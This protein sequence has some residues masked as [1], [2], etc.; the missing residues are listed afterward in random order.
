MPAADALTAASPLSVLMREGSVTE[1]REAERSTFMAAMLD[2]RINA[3]GYAAYVSAL[4]AVYAALEAVGRELAY[5]EVV[6]AIVDPRL[7][8]LTALDEDLRYW[9]Q[10]AARVPAEVSPTAV[11]AYVARL[12]ETVSD[13]VLYVAHHYTRYLGD[14][15]GGQAVG[16]ILAR[17]YGIER[18]G[19]GLAFYEFPLIEKPK[20]YKDRYRAQL[21]ALP[22]GPDDQHR[23]VQEVRVAF[24]H[25]GAMFSELSERLDE[26]TA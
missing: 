8:R 26:Y 3:T 6:G 19:A 12:R 10:R 14:L 22:L 13:P 16:R 24:T 9:T 11:G 1:H 17:T 7:E 2:G 15:S 18:G 5:H 21:D 4:R 23:V 20:P 25:N